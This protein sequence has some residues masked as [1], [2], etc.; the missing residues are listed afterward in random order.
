MSNELK[1]L[2]DLQKDF[3]LGKDSQPA[4]SVEAFNQRTVK[5]AVRVNKLELP[6]FVGAKRV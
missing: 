2:T 4:Q 5:G 6:S 1:P 3:D